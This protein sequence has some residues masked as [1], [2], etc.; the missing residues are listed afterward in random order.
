MNDSMLEAMPAL[1][2]L[3]GTGRQLTLHGCSVTF[4]DNC[5]N[6]FSDRSRQVQ[7]TVHNHIRIPSKNCIIYVNPKHYPT[8]PDSPANRG[9]DGYGGS[10]AATDIGNQHDGPP[11]RDVESSP[12]NC[13]AD[14]GGGGHDGDYDRT[15]V[16]GPSFIAQPGAE[17]GHGCGFNVDINVGVG[18]SHSSKT[19]TWIKSNGKRKKRQGGAHTVKI[20]LSGSSRSN[21]D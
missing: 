21:D 7:K 10:E 1:P 14:G 5:A 11:A 12:S 9:L 16:Y 2:N 3:K 6:C 13:A 20:D 15:Q 17:H 18:N 4:N 19:K 8:P